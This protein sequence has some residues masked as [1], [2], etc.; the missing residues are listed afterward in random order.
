MKTKTLLEI[1]GWVVDLLN[2]VKFHSKGYDV[3]LGGGYLRDVY[4]KKDYKDVDVFLVP[5]EGCEEKYIHVPNNYDVLYDINCEWL[6]MKKRG[7]CNLKG[8]F[9]NK[10]SITGNLKKANTEVQFIV[11]DKVLTQEELCADM[12]ITLNQ[13]QW[14]VSVKRASNL[15]MCKCT[16]SFYK[17]HEDKEITFAHMYDRYRMYRRLERMQEKFPDYTTTTPIEDLEDEYCDGGSLNY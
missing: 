17:A 3:Y 7:V 5:K 1:E 8:L 11:Y 13:I 14:K 6:D 10:K 15:Y 12:D 16:E 4:T 2:E 9:P